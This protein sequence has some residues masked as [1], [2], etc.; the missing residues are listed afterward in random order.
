MKHATLVIGRVKYPVVT[1]TDND[2]SRELAAEEAKEYFSRVILASRNTY[3]KERRAVH[4][5]RAAF[6]AACDVR[7]Y[8][9]ALDEYN[10]QPRK[11]GITRG[12][13]PGRNDEI[14]I[15]GRIHKVPAGTAE[16]FI[17]EE[18]N[19]RHPEPEPPAEEWATFDY[20]FNQKSTEKRT[21]KAEFITGLHSEALKFDALTWSWGYPVAA[22]MNELD[23]LTQDGWKLVHVSE[24]HGLYAGADVSDEAFLTRV[25]YLLCSE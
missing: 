18:M 2:E 25:R 7:T 5:Q 10:S 6:K 3:D 8:Q 24:D 19:R 15:E 23:R 11:F 13:P 20:W 22:A 16:K 4:A 14:T 17:T 9:Q 12:A 21:W 1:V